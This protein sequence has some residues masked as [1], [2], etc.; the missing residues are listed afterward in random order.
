MVMDYKEKNQ[1]YNDVISN[2]NE[3][4][5]ELVSRT[6]GDIKDYVNANNPILSHTMPSCGSMMKN[7]D[8]VDEDLTAEEIEALTQTAEDEI[9][10][11]IDELTSNEIISPEITGL[12]EKGEPG[13]EGGGVEGYVYVPKYT[14]P[15]W[16]DE[17]EAAVGK[18]I[19]TP[20]KG[21]SGTDYEEM[22][23]YIEQGVMIIRR[24]KRMMVQ[25]DKEIYILLDQSGSMEWTTGVSGLNFL[26]LLGGF[27]PL[28]GEEYSGYYWGGDHMSMAEYE[29]KVKI[30]KI[31]TELKDVSEQILINGRGG[32]SFD[33]AFRKLGDI[34]RGKQEENSDYEM[35]VI[36]FSDMEI[37]RHEWLNYKK[38]GPDKILFVTSE[39]Q[40]SELQI[41]ENKWIHNSDSHKIILIN[42]ENTKTK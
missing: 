21:R 8:I 33:G 32:T 31:Q 2:L 24:P 6:R 12:I 5:E 11:I 17:I 13:S 35:C 39:S 25:E 1:K 37:N 23:T 14:I 10:D 27:I 22:Q 7:E 36:F 19:G 28:L 20:D 41:E 30:P 9:S 4:L 42:I 3:E 18:M 15:E 29:S 34:E 26:Q 40:L 16:F 38:Y